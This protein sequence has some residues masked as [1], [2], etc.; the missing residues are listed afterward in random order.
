[1]SADPPADLADQIQLPTGFRISIWADNI[2]D[3]TEATG[4]RRPTPSCVVRR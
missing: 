1:M 2:T 3:G 4:P